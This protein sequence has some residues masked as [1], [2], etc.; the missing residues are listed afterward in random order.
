MQVS[1]IIQWMAESEFF[2]PVYD[3]VFTN[4]PI[5]GMADYPFSGSRMAM[6]GHMGTTV[7]HSGLVLYQLANSVTW[8][9]GYALEDAASDMGSDFREQIMDDITRLCLD[10]CIANSGIVDGSGINA[11]CQV[12]LQRKS[13]CDYLEANG[14]LDSISGI[15]F[16]E[17]QHTRGLTVFGYPLITE[18]LSYLKN[19]EQ[20]VDCSIYV[21]IEIFPSSQVYLVRKDSGI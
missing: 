8:P 11:F 9:M 5:S 13:D 6:S 3:H 2:F 17:D 7:Q 14:V 20:H 19:A 1:G 10:Y 12:P 4:V 16:G 21:G 15:A 18:D